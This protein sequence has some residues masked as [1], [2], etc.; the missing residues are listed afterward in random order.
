MC[1]V[2]KVERLKILAIIKLYL[3]SSKF[4]VH[5]PK[6]ER[7][8]QS[9]FARTVMLRIFRSLQEIVKDITEMSVQI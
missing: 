5:K 3:K 9:K 8:K 4:K 6:I 7:Q 2:M 1:V